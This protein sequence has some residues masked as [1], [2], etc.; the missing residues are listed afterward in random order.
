MHTY[1]HSYAYRHHAGNQEEFGRLNAC[2]LVMHLRAAQLGVEEINR[3]EDVANFAESFCWA[4]GNLGI[5]ITYMSIYMYIYICLFRYTYV[6]ICLCIFANIFIWLL[7]IFIY[8][9]NS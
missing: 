8:V 9:Y 2:E 1:I 4:V 6:Y 3:G 7:I 5:F